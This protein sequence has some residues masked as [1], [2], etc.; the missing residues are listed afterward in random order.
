MVR[1]KWNQESEHCYRCECRPGRRHHLNHLPSPLTPQAGR[2]GV[3]G[4]GPP[5]GETLH[6]LTR[7]PGRGAPAPHLPIQLI[8]P[9]SKPG[10]LPPPPLLPA[11]AGGKEVGCWCMPAPCQGDILVQEFQA[12]VAGWQGAEVGGGQRGDGG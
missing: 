1:L 6:L 4:A 12:R 5:S 8:P 7:L 11:P 2:A 3:V 10:L 9:N